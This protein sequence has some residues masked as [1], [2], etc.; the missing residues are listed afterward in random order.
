MYNASAA[1]A[2]INVRG[3]GVSEY[4]YSVMCGGKNIGTNGS[5]AVN[6][7]NEYLLQTNPEYAFIMQ[8]EV[9]LLKNKVPAQDTYN[10]LMQNISKNYQGKIG[11][12]SQFF[13]TGPGYILSLMYYASVLVPELKDAFDITKEYQFFMGTLVGNQELANIPAFVP[14]E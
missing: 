2:T 9:Y 8:Q 3:T 13:G 10:D 1:A 4:E 5:Y 11:V 7:F 12:F 6:D 14:I